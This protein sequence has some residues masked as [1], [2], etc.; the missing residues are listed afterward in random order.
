MR[1]RPRIMVLDGDY[2]HTLAVQ[3]ELKQHLNAEII[4][5]ASSPRSPGH[6]S[7]HTD[8]RVVAPPSS[9]DAFGEA[10]LEI[11]AAHQPDLI[12][13]VGFSATSVVI[14]REAELRPFSRVL[15]PEP[16]LF[17]IAAS[18]TRT[19]HAAEAAGVRAPLEYGTDQVELSKSLARDTF[20]IFAKARFER[21]GVSTALVRSVEELERFDAGPLGGDV[22]FQ[23][24]INGNSFTYAHCG[25]FVKGEAVVSMEHIEQRSVPRRGGSGTR[26]QA[27]AI[28]ELAEQATKL[29]T[30]LSWTGIAQVEFKVAATGEFIL[31][32]INPKLWASYALASRSGHAIA[33]AAAAQELDINLPESAPPRVGM[34]MVFPIREFLHVAAHFSEENV[35]ASAAAMLWPPARADFDVADVRAHLP[36]RQRPTAP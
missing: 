32:E 10:L 12:V 33:A 1:N 27:A 14:S 31:M 23:E 19:Y 30:H 21:G 29:L 9:S 11:A 16:K 13:P 36:R 5:V 4:S 22:I 17:A 2:T 7:R 35:I 28:P 3:A 26:V 18:K 6:L 24:Y 15:A 20:P 8:V 34:S 25:Y